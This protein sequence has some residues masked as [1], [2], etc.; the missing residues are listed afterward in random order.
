MSVDFLKLRHRASHRTAHCRHG[1]SVAIEFLLSSSHFRPAIELNSF[2]G[3]ALEPRSWRVGVD[4]RNR[5]VRRDQHRCGLWLWALR[6]ALYSGRFPTARV[7]ASFLVR[8]RNVSSQHSTGKGV[9]RYPHRVRCN[10]NEAMS[11]FQ[12]RSILYLQASKQRHPEERGRQGCSN[13]PFKE[14]APPPAKQ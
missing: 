12:I 5:S 7:A 4:V 9:K 11:R 6:S 1:R 13:R 3:L 14:H 10:E 2:F 8:A